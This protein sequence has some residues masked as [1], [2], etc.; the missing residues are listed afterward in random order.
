MTEHKNVRVSISPQAILLLLGTVLGVWLLFQLRDII[1][2]FL[3]VLAITVAFSPIIKAWER[4]I[5][6]TLAIVLLYLSLIAIFAV[7]L[8]LFVPPLVHQLNDLITYLEQAFPG[9]T[10]GLSVFEKIRENASLIV[11]GS[12]LESAGKIITEF[13]GSFGA[14]FSTTIG[15]IGGVVALVTVFISSFYLLM[16][17]QNFEHFLGTFLS[18]RRR[19]RVIATADKISLKIGDWMRGQLLLMLI[20]GT[21]NGLG[22]AV[23]GIPYALLLG[24][25]AGLT[26]A[27]PVVGPLL[28]AAPAVVL[29]FV[30]FGWVQAL[31]VLVLFLVVQQ[32]ENH[33]LVP[34]IMGKALGLS[35][36]TIIFAVLIG[37][38]LLGL[39]GILIA[40]PVAAV[41][42]VIIE[43]LRHEHPKGAA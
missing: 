28:G 34:K 21:I 1:V 3:V 38:K 6:R 23:I 14:V 43:E 4:F 19:K 15:V 27:L 35:P 24:L 13:Q 5:P 20:I 8:A 26:E 32:I 31:I 40:V 29:A 16:E 41:I 42:S 22:L 36:V 30:Q 17:E 18:D 11:S 39:V 37:G 12:G 10:E 2:L 7:I 25:W 33:F 9:N